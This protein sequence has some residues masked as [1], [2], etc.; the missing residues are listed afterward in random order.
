M[1]KAVFLFLIIFLL[2]SCVNVIDNKDN[3]QATIMPS[4]TPETGDLAETP[5]D[6]PAKEET[7]TQEI[8]EPQYTIY[9]SPNGNDS[10]PGTAEK[11]LASI[12]QARDLI[13]EFS[14]NM[15]KSISV[16]VHGGTYSIVEP[17]QFTEE[18]SGKNG[19]DII[20]QAFENETPR[21]SGGIEITNWESVPDSNLWKTTLHDVDLFRQLYVNGKRAQRAVSQ[22][23]ITG[24][25]W[26]SG[27]RRERDGISVT[28]SK[29]PDIARPQDLELHWINDWKDFRLLVN[30]I[31]END[32]GTKT[33]WMKQPYYEI[34]LGM[35]NWIPK[36]NVPFYLENAFEL[37]DEPGEWYFNSETNNLYYWPQSNETL[38][39]TNFVIPQTEVLLEISG[40][41]VGGEVQNLVFKG[42]TF[43]H[44]SWTRASK[45]GTFGWQA[46]NLIV[47]HQGRSDM[48]L[49]H[50][51][52]NSAK[53]VLFEK[54]RFEH[55]GGVGLHL[56]NNVH[57]ITVKGN[58]FT[59]ISDAAIV[60]G[61]WDHNFIEYIHEKEPNNLLIANN[62][63]KDTGVEYWGAPAI[64]AYYV[65]NV[66]IVNNEI[67]NVPYTGISIGWGW[68]YHLESTT[69]HDNIVARNLITD[70]AQI[71]RDAGGIYTLGQQPGTLIEDNVI[72]RMKND[73]ACLYTD[74][75]SAFIT[76]QSNV[77][78]STPEWM[79]A[80]ID[81]VHDIHYL[82]NY[83][84]TYNMNNNGININIENTI[85]VSGQNWPDEAQDIIDNAGLEVPYSYL[86]DWINN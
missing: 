73:Y 72:R 39:N 62:L 9:V 58:L 30:D 77:C 50:V 49:A 12:Q 75:G 23:Q 29:I 69:S 44:A 70:T 34:A 53:N 16:I 17:I 52:L 3:M 40:R 5:T 37:L 36:Y 25:G 83:T 71:A 60:I 14:S 47:N 41:G 51:K 61:H 80:W 8:N 33:I 32:N 64:T 48:T 82:N 65:N 46:Q 78:D 38:E 6:V 19:F 27:E 13:R 59:D 2:S 79:S 22:T 57:E 21:F 18:D 74:E 11:P 81:T 20:Y 86:H 85:H 42:L 10:N 1:K 43:E 76:L 68:A 28:S 84:N 63:I 66:K 15:E 56:N 54:C 55:L 35:E 31:E 4:T 26:V 24:T 45:I 7:P 67:S